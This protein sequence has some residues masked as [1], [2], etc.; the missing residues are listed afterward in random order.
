M[1]ASRSR[2]THW[3]SALAP[4]AEKAVPMMHAED[5]EGGVSGLQY[6]V[7]PRRAKP[8]PEVVVMRAGDPRLGEFVDRA[9][10]LER[11]RNDSGG[12][13]VTAAAAALSAAAG[14]RW[15]SI[16]HDHEPFQFGSKEYG[17]TEV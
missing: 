12:R 5:S 6:T 15:S 16:S 9:R 13:G 4:A 1:T 17:E 14:S 10:A 3:L 8:M 11:F 7:R 2:S